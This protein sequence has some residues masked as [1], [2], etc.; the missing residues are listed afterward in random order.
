MAPTTIEATLHAAGKFVHLGN[1]PTI[2]LRVRLGI[3]LSRGGILR[4]ARRV[5][6]RPIRLQVDDQL[7]LLLVLLCL[8]DDHKFLHLSSLPQIRPA[9]HFTKW[10]DSLP[11]S[12]D[13]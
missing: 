12:S 8:G 10:G 13:A 1:G 7:L 11:P 6:S 3:L 5:G 2:P 4:H 9:A